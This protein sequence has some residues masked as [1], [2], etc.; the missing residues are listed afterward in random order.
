MY[1]LAWYSVVLVFCDTS[2]FMIVSLDRPDLQLLDFERNPKN[3]V[4]FIPYIQ[5]L[6]VKDEF[7]S[8]CNECVSGDV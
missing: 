6:C 3:S 2:F 7:T 8:C 5:S 4:F 1:P